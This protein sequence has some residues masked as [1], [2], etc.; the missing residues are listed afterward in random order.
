MNKYTVIFVEPG[1]SECW[2][3]FLCHADDDDHAQEQC[4]DAYPT[5]TVLWVNEGHGD[6]ARIMRGMEDDEP[7]PDQYPEDNDSPELQ[8]CD[9]WGTG[10][11]QYHGRM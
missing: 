10:E 4:E 11:G 5:A 7:H 8:N 1:L 2:Q 9:D 6:E 3:F